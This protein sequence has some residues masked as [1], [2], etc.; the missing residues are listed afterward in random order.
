MTIPTALVLGTFNTLGVSSQSY[1]A[2]LGTSSCVTTSI[3]N[4]ATTQVKWPIAG[5]LSNY[6]VTATSNGS[7]NTITCKIRQ[8]GSNS[9]VG[10]SFGGGV[11]GTLSDTTNSVSVAA[12]DLLGVNIVTGSGT[13]SFLESGEGIRWAPSSGN[14]FF[15]AGSGGASAFHA[16]TGPITN[17]SQLVGSQSGGTATVG[18]Q[19]ASIPVAG[20][21]SYFQM[22]LSANART[23]T[24]NFGININGTLGNGTISYTSGVFGSVVDTTHTDSIS[25]NDKLAVQADMGSSTGTITYHASGCYLAATTDGQGLTATASAA[26]SSLGAGATNYVGIAGRQVNGVSSE[27]V[28]TKVGTSLTSSQMSARTTTN[29]STANVAVKFRKNGANGNQSVTVTAGVANTFFQDTTNSDAFSASDLINYAMSG[30]ATGGVNFT[31]F[32]M[33]MTGSASNPVAQYDWPLPMRAPSFNVLASQPLGSPLILSTLAG[34]DALPVRQQQWP[35]PVLALALTSHLTQPQGSPPILTVLRGLDALPVRQPDWP[36][37]KLAWPPVSHFT[38]P[39]GSPSILTTLAGKD[40]LPVRQ[41]D[42]P[43]PQQPVW[44]TPVPF[45]GS[46]LTFLASVAPVPVFGSAQTPPMLGASGAAAMASQRQGSPLILTVLLGLDSLP[47]RQQDW[48]SFKPARNDAHLVS[49]PGGSPLVLT[50]LL[51]RDALPIRQFDWPNP[52]ILRNDAALRSQPLGTPLTLIS[53]FVPALPPP[54]FDWPQPKI[55]R[56]EAAFVSQPLGSPLILTVLAGLDVLPVRQNHWPLPPPAPSPLASLVS[57]PLG[58]PLC[59]SAFVPAAFIVA[60]YH[61]PLPFQPRNDAAQNS[62]PQGSPN[63]LTNLSGRDALPIRQQDWPLPVRQ[64]HDGW[65]SQVTAYNFRLIGKDTLPVRQ[66]HWPAAVVQRNDAWMYSQPLGISLSAMVI[67]NAVIVASSHL[68]GSRTAGNLSG[69]NSAANMTGQKTGS[70]LSG[71]LAMDEK[72]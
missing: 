34:A 70:I 6:A 53:A 46:A 1:F 21:I 37:A 14:G 30:G 9:S 7:T 44:P 66:Q 43:R 40:A 11:F 71:N 54:C 10:V 61:W 41:Q 68:Q 72:K 35:L 25:A 57:Q 64:Q 20:T 60:Q 59:I 4:E 45:L 39:Q 5:T 19:Q 51:G 32:T 8:N 48:P 26:A 33:M 12:N 62:Q 65:R 2:P 49:Q 29:A 22:N 24:T 18:D 16:G 63:I 42:W 15:I 3:N 17:Y 13:V 50:T 47:V 28:Q 56:N 58:T 36:G 27:T 38:Q 23:T 69:L 67:I 52:I 55:A 31:Q